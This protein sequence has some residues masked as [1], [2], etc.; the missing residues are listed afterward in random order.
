[1]EAIRGTLAAL[2]IGIAAALVILALAILP[3]LTP[4]WVAFGQAQADAT[5][6]TGYTTDQLGTVTDAILADLVVGPPDFDVT[7]DGVPVLEER[8]RQHMRDVRGVFA[9]FFAAAAVG[10]IVLVAAFLLARGPERRARLWRRLSRT[11]VVVVAVTIIGGLVGVVFFDQAFELFHELFFPAGSYLFDAATE[12]LVQIFPQAFWVD[13]TIGVGAV[14]VL[15]SA[16]LWWLGRRRATALEARVTSRRRPRDGTR[17][18]AG[19]VSGGLPL[20]RLFGIEVRVS[21][22]WAVLVAVVTVIGAQQAAA[23]A[24]QLAA[25]VHWLIGLLVAFAFLASVVAHE[26]AHALVGRRR[27]VEARTIVLGFAGGLAPL[28]IEAARA[29]DELAIAISGPLVSLGIAVLA[30]R[31]RWSRGRTGRRSRWSRAAPS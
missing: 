21:L 1:M 18:G 10:A 31:W 22:A 8:E 30:I 15:L 4:A 25:P 23:G 5:A 20:A 3:F 14:V 9:G 7:M 29:G 13:S 27:G 19:P 24:P 6:W 16:G 17:P 28:S 11:G 12:K 2:V 26:L